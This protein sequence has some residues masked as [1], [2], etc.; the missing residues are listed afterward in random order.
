MEAYLGIDVGS[1]TTKLAV[2]DAA[3]E[4]VAGLCL[5]TEGRTV[6]VVQE[7]LRQMRR[8][9]PVDVEIRGVA[10]TGSAR[11][12]VGAV[13]GAARLVH[14]NA[15]AGQ[16]RFKGFNVSEIE[17]KTSSFACRACPVA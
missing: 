14:E 6:A 2:L 3:D 1:V 16:G 11:Y 7:G 5:P 8:E 4:L 9:F 12:L 13:V 10:A 15:P 17:F